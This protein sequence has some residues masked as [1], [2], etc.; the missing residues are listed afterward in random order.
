MTSFY[1]NIVDAKGM[2]MEDGTP[3]RRHRSW[4]PTTHRVL[5]EGQSF[6]GAENLWKRFTSKEEFQMF[7][8][9]VATLQEGEYGDFSWKRE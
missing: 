9:T 3:E 7:I 2:L 5:F 6:F 4:L 8:H 1:V